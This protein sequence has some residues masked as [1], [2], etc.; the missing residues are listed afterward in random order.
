M[1]MASD[2]GRDF[3]TK[4]LPAEITEIAPD[5]SNVRLLLA[6][7]SA[8]MAH[9][10][11]PPNETSQAVTNRTVE[12]IWYFISGRGEMWRKQRDTEEVVPVE[13]GVCITIPLG[14]RF[15]FRTLGEES[16]EAVGV[17]IPPWPGP[18]EAMVVEGRWTPTIR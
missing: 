9:Y 5:G 6:L 1:N 18:T 3:E 2:P 11:L 10:E 16:L 13:A 4:E 7:A 17:V 12:E 8:V 15:Q 14:T